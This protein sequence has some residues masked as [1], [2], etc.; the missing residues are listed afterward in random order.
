MG[1]SA[2]DTAHDRRESSTETTRGCPRLCAQAAAPRCAPPGAGSAPR[3][4]RPARWSA[5]CQQQAVLQ[6]MRRRDAATSGMVARVR[7]VCR[8]RRTMTRGA[9]CICMVTSMSETGT[10]GDEARALPRVRPRDGPAAIPRG[11]A[12]PTARG[13]RT[14]R[15][16]TP[17]GPRLLWRRAWWQWAWRAASPSWR[18]PSLCLGGRCRPVPGV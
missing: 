10:I 2:G 7:S 3:G 13:S 18:R 5:T 11:A 15:P 16:G 17:R 9:A 4:G 12:I 8:T 1:I 6:W 14:S